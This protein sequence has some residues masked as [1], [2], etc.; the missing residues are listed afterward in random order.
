MKISYNWLKEYV[1]VDLTHQEVA[2]LLTDC[3]LEVESFEEYQTCKGGLKGLVIGKVL[4]CEKHPDAD[5]LSLTTVDIGTENPLP[6]VCGASNVRAGQHVVVAAVGTELHPLEGEPFKIKKSKIR[7]KDSEGMICAEDEI[8]LGNSHEGIMV[9]EGNPEV[10]IPAADYFGVENDVVFEIGLTPN[11][12]DAAS[13]I[14]VARDLTALLNVR[15]NQ[16]TTLKYPDIQQF[17]PQLKQSPISVFVEDAEACPRYTSLFIRNITVQSSPAWLQNRLKSI[18]VR[19]INNVVDATQY[20][21][22]E[23]GQPLHAFDAGKILGNKVIVKKA[24]DKTRFTTLDGVERELSKDDLMI[25]NAEQPMCIAGVFGGEDSGVKDSTQHIFLESAYF[26]PVG[27]RKTAK[28]HALKT[29]ASFRY[30]RG[31][32]PEITIYA[33]KRAAMLIQNLAGGE[34]S[35]I[36]DF[37]PNPIQKKTVRLRYKELNNIVGK[38]IDNET[39]KKILTAIELEIV[40]E[41]EKEILL[42]IPTNKVDVTREIDVIEEFL[43][44]YGYNQV[45]ISEKMSYTLSFL[46]KNPFIQ[47]KETISNYLSDNG[48]NETMNNSLTKAE[49]AENFDFID[50]MQTVSLLNPL[51]RDLAN[52]RQTLIF[53]GLENII[54][55]INHG[56]T[57]LKLYEF[58]TVYRKNSETTRNEDVTKRFSEKEFLGIFVSGKRQAES[59]KEKQ[60]DVD[61][62]YL[63]NLIINSLNR[64]N[65]SLNTLPTKAFES[66]EAMNNVLQYCVGEAVFVAIGQVNK[67]LLKFF[68]IKQPVFYA[69]IDCEILGKLTKGRKIVYEELNK[70]PEVSRD[71]AL[72][73]DKQVTYRDIESLAF[74]T[75]RKYLKSMNLFDVYQGDKLEANKKSYAIRLILCDK[76]KTLTNNEINA[77][78]DKLIVA[79]ETK[80]GAR[81]R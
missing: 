36:A 27:I 11:R 42:A 37:Y 4:T 76:D 14:G 22:F 25:C 28:N 60:E 73:I 19:P 7:G 5:R 72:L 66:T 59:W 16:N 10:G 68:D 65:V 9:L 17:N 39:V 58:G 29:D 47:I 78:M 48:F 53:S 44:I 45:E 64:V 79:F 40:K 12:S 15:K 62:Y 80:L 71:L 30:E 57:D 24:A 33:A 21:L 61:F 49:Y 43:R 67:K 63:K 75:E 23:T 69:E 18:G 46:P 1:N 54:H 32:D 34:I 77:V 35:E 31:C 51:S 6:I 55:N 2:D 8:G 20:V 56:T 26:Q 41:T 3:G 52:L 70:F 13:H 38:N 74:K 50:K 81:L